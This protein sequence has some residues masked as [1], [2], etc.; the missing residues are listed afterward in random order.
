MA[1]S[2]TLLGNPGIDE[3]TAKKELMKVRRIFQRAKK[4]ATRNPAAKTAIAKE[5]ESRV[6][7]SLLPEGSFDNGDGTF[8]LPTGEIVEPE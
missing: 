3:V 5:A 7:L 2:A 1:D 4:S 8:T 6:A